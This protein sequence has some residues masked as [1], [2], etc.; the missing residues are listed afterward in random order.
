M[1]PLQ[2][3]EKYLNEG[4]IDEARKL[5][6]RLRG[7]DSTRLAILGAIEQKAGN[8]SE[9]SLL[10]DRSLKI[11][12][13]DPIA[14]VNYGKLLL[15]QKKARLSIPL[16]EQAVSKQTKAN[17][18]TMIALAAAYVEVDQFERAEALLSPHVAE[19][20]LPGADLML[21]YAN[22]LRAM[23]RP[24]E[25]LE[26]LA[27]L[28]D[29]FPDYHAIE[30][31]R[32]DCYA[33]LDPVVAQQMFEASEDT[34]TPSA[35]WNR[36]FVELRL[37]RFEKGWEL[38]ENGL[39]DVIGKIGRPLPPQVRC[40]PIVTDLDLLDP[41]KWTVLSTEQ[42]IGDQV[43]FLGCLSEALRDTHRPVMVCEERMVQLI[44]RSF[45]E[46]PTY[47]YSFVPNLEQQVGRINGIFPIGS[48]QKYYRSSPEHFNRVKIPYI[49][50]NALLQEKY[51]R[52]LRERSPNKKLVALSWTGGYWERQKQ[53]KSIGFEDL[54]RH[55][56][57]HRETH[58]FVCLQYG[59]ITNDKQRA[60]ELN[61][62]ITFIQG[63]NFKNQI[64]HWFALAMATDHCIS[65][66][67]AIVHFLGAAGRRVELL[68]TEH[69]AP[70]IWGTGV[71]ASLP[72]PDVRI[73]RRTRGETTAAYLERIDESLQ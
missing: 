16:L 28:Q 64:D 1:N 11:N 67:T 51:S 13:V 49:R 10:Y 54:M 22:I 8:E 57:R 18:P 7:A 3:I 60:K 4:L 53:T 41:N 30:K 66:S 21:A 29:R 62:P 65:V 25:A 14:T 46:L 45:P 52:I 19:G 32:A 31:A 39:L 33:E 71:G 27:R 72:Y 47:D 59:D 37:Q 58:H 68:L 61:F 26:I 20:R 43:L 34:A 73:H 42:G 15:K 24:R 63:L 48:L 40:L 55:L 5:A 38:Y 6:K 70:F 36:S 17:E 44:Q 56:A 9:A 2:Q 12:P 23:L 35:R 69:Q 50:A